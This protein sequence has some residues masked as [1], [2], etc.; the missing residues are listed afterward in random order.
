ME[1]L[2]KVNSVQLYLMWKNLSIG[3]LLFIALIALTTMVPFYLAPALSLT[4]AAILY[5]M[6]YNN[7]SAEVNSC[8]LT[9]YSLFYCMI[10]YSFI[11]IIFNLGYAW[12]YYLVP[13]ELIFFNKNYVPGLML[14]PI[15]TV[16]LIILYLRRQRLQLCVSCR[17]INGE[18]YERGNMGKILKYESSLQL[19]NLIGLFAVLSC[20]IWFYYLYFF[21]HVD[22]NARDKF[23]FSWLII[24]AFVL[25]EVYFAFRY[26]NLYLDLKDA[27]EIITPDELRDMS[28]KTYLRFYVFC[29]DNIYVNPHA[30]DP[31][32]PYRE[33]IDTPFET[34][35][36]AS[37]INISDVKRTIEK[38][39]GVQGG[40]LRFFFGRKSHDL[41][42]HSMLRYF[43]FLDGDISDYPELNVDGEWLP[44]SKLKLIYS[45]N[46]GKL[47][48]MTVADLTRLATI[49]LTEKIFDE[50][51]YRKTKLKTY[52]PSFSLIDVRNS[53]LD[54]QDDK[55]IRISLF[56]SDT[57]FYSMKRWWKKFS[58]NSV[59]R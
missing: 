51:G 20:V 35:R 24:I 42:R 23:V 21:I 9:V 12:G 14:C 55:W 53:E 28:T 5:T 32:A 33:I 39:T 54:F 2:R 26:Y 11:T 50:R 59:D 47:S 38:M 44:F 45:H 37:G 46:P 41:E 17:L 31:D 4:A 29:G 8:M 10:A 49:I 18:T 3:L 16:T 6:L 15:S 52:Q 58:S 57:P 34:R 27:N 22:H 40:E 36:S 30:I 19:R 48:A 25:D 43:Y 13:E 1:D 56:N 7:K